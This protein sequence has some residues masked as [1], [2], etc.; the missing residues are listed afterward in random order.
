MHIHG[1]VLG[2]AVSSFVARIDRYFRALVVVDAYHAAIHAGR[3]FVCTDYDTDTDIA[4]PKLWRFTTPAAADGEIHLTWSINADGPATV[5]LYEGPTSTGAGT[6]LTEI[7]RKRESSRTATLAVAKDSTN[8]APGTLLEIVRLG[9][10]GN[11]AKSSGGAY[12]GRH[13]WELKPST[14]YELE[15]T[16]DADNT[17]LWMNLDWYEHKD[18]DINDDDHA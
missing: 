1:N 5:R 3:A 2:K 7:N 16:V 10:A 6:G 9:V 13:E 4:T 15:I 11:P 17:Q 12:E 18:S 8:S 14:I